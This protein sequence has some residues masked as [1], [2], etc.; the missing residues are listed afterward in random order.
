ML[1]ANIVFVPA[2]FLFK[3]GS[4]ELG[5]VDKIAFYCLLSNMQKLKYLEK[6]FCQNYFDLL[7]LFLHMINNISD[8]LLIKLKRPVLMVTHVIISFKIKESYHIL[9]LIKHYKIH[10]TK[11]R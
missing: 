7:L 4:A 6:I 9:D 11:N 10:S 5:C 2:K 8:L 1:N 3:I